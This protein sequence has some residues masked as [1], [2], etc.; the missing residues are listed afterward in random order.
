MTTDTNT[1]RETFDRLFNQLLST[2]TE[3]RDIRS[4][5]GG[6]NELISVR[7]RLHAIRS[8]LALARKGISAVAITSGD[9]SN[10]ET[11]D[12]DCHPI[13]AE[14]RWGVRNLAA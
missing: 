7:D 10:P 4:G 9:T 6:I 8:E 1:T 12:C 11:P 2:L 13:A 14:R 5:A 3:E